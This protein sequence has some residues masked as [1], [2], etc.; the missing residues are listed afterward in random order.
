MLI[1]CTH[2][3]LSHQ[4]SHRRRRR[5]RRRSFL[6]LLLLLYLIKVSFVM[7]HS[8]S[9]KGDPK[10]RRQLGANLLSGYAEYSLRP[11]ANK[12][13]S[14]RRTIRLLVA[15]IFVSHVSLTDN[16]CLFCRGQDKSPRNTLWAP[17]RHLGIL[18]VVVGHKTRVVVVVFRTL[19]LCAT[20]TTNERGDSFSSL[21]AVIWRLTI[22]PYFMM[23]LGCFLIAHFNN[24]SF[25]V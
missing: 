3:K 4:S 22:T 2:T 6:F 11:R 7:L 20:I 1:A 12:T 10:S 17:F 25:R 14:D 18:L 9:R 21:K 24:C 19:H 15:I 16:N 8:S 13:A 5:R 23:S